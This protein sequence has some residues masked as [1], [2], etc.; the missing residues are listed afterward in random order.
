MNVDEKFAMAAKWANFDIF[1]DKLHCRCDRCLGILD[2]EDD[3]EEILVD[4]MPRE[5]FEFIDDTIQPMRTRLGFALPVNSAHRCPDHPD[6]KRKS[7]PGPHQFCAIDLGVSHQRADKVLALSY[8]YPQITGRGIN[9][10]GAVSG[11]FLHFDPLGP[12]VDRPRPHIWT[13]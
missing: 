9:Q 12:T 11:R 5:L 4:Q 2:R 13:Y 3:G 10:K 8:D 7:A 6:E 1:E